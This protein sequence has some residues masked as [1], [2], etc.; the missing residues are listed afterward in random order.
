M[1]EEERET[2]SSRHDQNE[3]D[4]KRANPLSDKTLKMLGF[5]STDEDIRKLFILDEMRHDRLVNNML[6]HVTTKLVG[7]RGLEL[8]VRGFPTE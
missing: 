3:K 4:V 8:K 2:I 7:A 6:L 1:S 5:L